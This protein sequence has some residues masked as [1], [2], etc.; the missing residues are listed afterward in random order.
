MDI[1]SRTKI[2]KSRKSKIEN[3]K[4]HRKK[5]IFTTT[6]EA[7]NF[8]N[9]ETICCVGSHCL[10]AVLWAMCIYEASEENFKAIFRRMSDAGIVRCC[11]IE[12]ITL[13]IRG[14]S[15]ER[16]E[17]FYSVSTISSVECSSVECIRVCSAQP[18]HWTA[19]KARERTRLVLNDIRRLCCARTASPQ[20]HRSPRRTAAACLHSFPY[21]F[22]FSFGS[23]QC[24]PI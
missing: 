2:N 17:R 20:P 1:D 22:S 10:R 5:I 15:S 19:E 11:V 16:G 7:I 12:R 9:K 18:V 23:L 14:P 8:C 4:S 21:I 3:C 24:I 6:V 13:F